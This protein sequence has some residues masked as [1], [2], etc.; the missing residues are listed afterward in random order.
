MKRY[1]KLTAQNGNRVRVHLDNSGS[2]V[3]SLYRRWVRNHDGWFCVDTGEFAQNATGWLQ[4]FSAG[5]R[6]SRH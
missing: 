4:M 5:E 3:D 6:S 2:G 1:I